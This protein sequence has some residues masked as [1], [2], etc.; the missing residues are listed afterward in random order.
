ME[1]AIIDDAGSFTRHILKN[2]FLTGAQV[3]EV[4]DVL[5]DQIKT[6]IK[7]ADG[8]SRAGSNRDQFMFFQGGV[9]GMLIAFKQVKE[10]YENTAWEQGRDPVTGDEIV[11]HGNAQ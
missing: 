1:Q 2:R 11:D 6:R 10:H 3:Q 9:M 4:I 5:D 7:A 8:D